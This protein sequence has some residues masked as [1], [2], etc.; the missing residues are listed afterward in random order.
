M[1]TGKEI[2][3]IQVYELLLNVFQVFGVNRQYKFHT[4]DEYSS[5]GP[6]RVM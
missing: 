4:V 6:T 2:I 3:L 5:L 1:V